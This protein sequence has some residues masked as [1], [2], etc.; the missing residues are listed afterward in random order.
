[1][2]YIILRRK[3]ADIIQAVPI[4]FPDVLVHKHVAQA[5]KNLPGNP[6]FIE[7]KVYSAGDINFHIRSCT[8]RSTT[9]NISS[10]EQDKNI[11]TLAD[12]F[13]ELDK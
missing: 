12:Y 4:I 6:Y 11:I 10:T 13:Q 8:G 7:N 1:M 5:I 3:I 9:L 2:K